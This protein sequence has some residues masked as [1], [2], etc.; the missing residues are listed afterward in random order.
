MIHHSFLFS[1]QSHC[2]IW[3]RSKCWYQY[4]KPD[5]EYMKTITTKI[6]QKKRKETNA[7]KFDRCIGML[8]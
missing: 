6:Y 8:G 3:V 5:W 4:E 2:L 1:R 7:I